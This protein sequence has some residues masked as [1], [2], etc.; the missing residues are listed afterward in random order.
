MR[1]KKNVEVKVWITLWLFDYIWSFPEANFATY[2]LVILLIIIYN[3]HSIGVYLTCI[4]GNL[5]WRDT[6][7]EQ[8]RVNWLF[9]TVF[10]VHCA[11]IDTDEEGALLL[12]NRRLKEAR[13]CKVCM[14][15]EVNTVFL[16]C[17]HFV[18]CAECAKQCAK[19][20]Q[21]CPICCIYVSGTVRALR[22]WMLAF[23]RAV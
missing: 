9:D 22:S 5:G 13:T 19:Q 21:K 14:D 18:C 12:E 11:V 17:G 10:R 20:L 16:P 3:C 7:Y 23:L 8:F 4:S 1:R 2:F 15:N 6:T